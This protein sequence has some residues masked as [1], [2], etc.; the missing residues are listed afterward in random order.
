MWTVLLLV[1]QHSGSF[2]QGV[3]CSES[4]S[5]TRSGAE[6]HLLNPSSSLTSP[7]SLSS[8]C[9]LVCFMQLNEWHHS[10]FFPPF[11]FIRSAAFQWPLLSAFWSHMAA[12]YA[13]SLPRMHFSPWPLVKPK[14][15]FRQFSHV[16]GTN[17]PYLNPMEENRQSTFA[18]FFG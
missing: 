5:L 3:F 16:T 14:T 2:Q 10:C 6:I 1:G 15:T 13:P 18:Q 12:S 17:G 9:F 7:K 11:A 8:W 4:L